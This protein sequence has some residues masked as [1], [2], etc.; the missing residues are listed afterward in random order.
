[1]T[2][3]SGT[4]KGSVD[5]SDCIPQHGETKVTLQV[6]MEIRQMQ[7]TNKRRAI[8]NTA[9]SPN[10][11][12][13]RNISGRG[14]S[15]EHPFP[16]SPHR[17]V[18]ILPSIPSR[19]KIPANALNHRSFETSSRECV[20]P[21]ILGSR[22]SRAKD[23]IDTSSRVRRIRESRLAGNRDRSTPSASIVAHDMPTSPRHRF[24]SEDRYGALGFLWMPTRSW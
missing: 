19:S 11:K 2:N 10:D 23:E 17:N 13:T 4:S 9:A 6:E 8:T 7:N 21:F 15:K 20:L 24:H 16:H 12:V 3:P 14:N 1:M 18:L 5:D 22:R